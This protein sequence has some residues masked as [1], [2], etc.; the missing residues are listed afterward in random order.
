MEKIAVLLAFSAAFFFGLSHVLTKKGLEKASV[1]QSLFIS[2]LVNVIFLWILAFFF[3]PLELYLSSAVLIFAAAGCLAPGFGR[4][5]NITSIKHLGVSRAAPIVGTS[6]LFSV[7]AAIIFLGEEIRFELLL[8]TLVIFSGIVLIFTGEDGG[9]KRLERKYVLAALVA[10]MAY[11]FAI[12]IQKA[13]LTLLNYPILAATVTTTTSFLLLTVYLSATRQLHF[14]KMNSDGSFAALAGIA[15]GLAF[16]CNFGALGRE[17]VSAVVPITATF[18]LFGLVLSQ[19]FIKHHEKI[20]P[21][22]VIGALLAVCGVIIV[23]VI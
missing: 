5:F 16:L 4:L 21:R 6:T 1:L 19:I 18:P 17:D 12:P 9:G 7:F 10:A 15:T 22:V 8:A 14:A 20:T 23:S 2:L 3:V 11:G 13:G